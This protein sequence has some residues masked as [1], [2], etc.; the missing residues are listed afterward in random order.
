[1]QCPIF[2]FASN[3][4]YKSGFIYI[5]SILNASVFFNISNNFCEKMSKYGWNHIPYFS[6]TSYLKMKHIYS[7]LYLLK[8][9][10]E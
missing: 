4:I 10:K 8:Y 7:D 6:I 1:M 3:E 5:E 2:V 9:I